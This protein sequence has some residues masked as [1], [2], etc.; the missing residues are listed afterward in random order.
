[1][2]NDW[3]GACVYG[4]ANGGDKVEFWGS[5]ATL[6]IYYECG[7]DYISDAEYENSLSAIEKGFGC[8]YFQ[9]KGMKK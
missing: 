1:M 6:P 7:N 2:F 4:I 8:P 3:C 5:P 9:E